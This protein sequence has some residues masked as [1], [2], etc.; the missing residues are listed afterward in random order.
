MANYVSVTQFFK[1]LW[2]R[3]SEITKFLQN[4]EH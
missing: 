2:K 4:R 1:A 3:F